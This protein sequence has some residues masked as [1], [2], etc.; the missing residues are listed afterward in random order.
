MVRLILDVVALLV[1]V[2]GGW[3]L[4]GKFGSTADQVVKDVTGQKPQ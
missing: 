4:K 1:G 3:Y 2:A